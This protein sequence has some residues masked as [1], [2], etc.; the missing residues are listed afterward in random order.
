[1]YF[2]NFVPVTLDADAMQR[3]FLLVLFATF[4]LTTSAK[5]RGWYYTLTGT[6]YAKDSKDVLRNT[7]LMIGR[8]LVTTDSTGHYRVTIRG[9]T[10][11]R[12]S[13]QVIARCNEQAF[14][15]LVIRRVL[16][17][18][19]ITIPSHWKRFAFCVDS[20]VPCKEQ[21]RDLYVP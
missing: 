8:E 3:L 1:M 21:R 12:G 14:G 17:S 13:K 15:K 20:L 18:A 2:Q 11:D 16:S 4:A 19:S 7:A 6:A 9:V 10:C 5:G